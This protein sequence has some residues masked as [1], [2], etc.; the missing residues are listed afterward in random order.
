MPRDIVWKDNKL[1]I[2]RVGGGPGG[3]WKQSKQSKR[4]QLLGENHKQGTIYIL[5]QKE[6]W[7]GGSRIWEKGVSIFQAGDIKLERFLPT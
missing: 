4:T 1:N 2:F 3:G 6:D 5:R 7:F